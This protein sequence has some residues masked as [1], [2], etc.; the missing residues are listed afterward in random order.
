MNMNPLDVGFL[1]SQP[2]DGEEGLDSMQEDWCVNI[3]SHLVVT[4]ILKFDSGLD[5]EDYDAIGCF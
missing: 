4:L 2:T 1:D 5:R 3:F